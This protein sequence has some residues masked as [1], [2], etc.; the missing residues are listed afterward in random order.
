MC[1]MVKTNQQFGGEDQRVEDIELRGG[2]SERTDVACA[3]A[4]S[5]DMVRTIVVMRMTQVPM[6]QCIDAADLRM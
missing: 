1:N 5:T 4:A 3:G 6:R 2:V